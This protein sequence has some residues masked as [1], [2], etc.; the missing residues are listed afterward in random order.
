MYNNQEFSVTPIHV[1][2]DDGGGG[3][4]V[5]DDRTVQNR[6]GV[7]GSSRIVVIERTN[8]DASEVVV[9]S[10]SMYTSNKDVGSMI[11]V[12]DAAQSNQGEIDPATP[13]SLGRIWNLFT[14][15]VVDCSL[16]G[17]VLCYY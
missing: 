7:C 5:A 15:N 13:N 10:G 12:S 1:D 14:N 9:S 17:L 2:N 4:D 11:P 6:G 3:V 8:D 16:F